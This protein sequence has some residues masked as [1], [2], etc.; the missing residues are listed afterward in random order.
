MFDSNGDLIPDTHRPGP[1]EKCPVCERRVS[2]PKKDDSPTSKP[3]SY[4]VPIDEAD[5]HQDVLEAASKFLGTYERP[6]WQ[7][8]TYALALALVL[9]DEGMRGFAQRTADAA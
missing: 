1:G 7:F 2:H 6:F 3:R 5:A 4:R 8:Q 9:Q